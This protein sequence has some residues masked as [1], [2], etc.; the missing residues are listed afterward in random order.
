M[1]PRVLMAAGAG[2]Q[3]AVP[4]TEMNSFVTTS[5]QPGLEDPALE[6]AIHWAVA[7]LATD[8]LDLRRAAVRV[9]RSG[10]TTT[11]AATV[12]LAERTVEGRGSHA[13]AFAALHEAFAAL[14]RGS[15]RAA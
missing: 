10:K 4:V 13:D 11:I 7:R 8:G 6:A 2:P 3:R 5:F 12:Q 14:Q 9:E 15:K 1:K